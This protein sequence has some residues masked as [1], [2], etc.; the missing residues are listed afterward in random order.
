MMDDDWMKMMSEGS[1][2]FDNDFSNDLDGISDDIARYLN[3]QISDQ[4]YTPSLV[5]W[6]VSY[7]LPKQNPL[8]NSAL[9][10][11]KTF[12]SCA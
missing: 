6:L 7:F 12:L 10:K 3:I 8:W 1:V 2:L 4:L 5:S 11:S 9:P